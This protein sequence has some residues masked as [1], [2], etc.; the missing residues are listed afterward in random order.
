RIASF[1]PARRAKVGAAALVTALDRRTGFRAE[2]AVHAA[3]ASGDDPVDRAAR[4]FLERSPELADLVREA[5]PPPV[6]EGPTVVALRVQV[7]ELQRTVANL[8]KERDR[9]AARP[10]TDEALER[11]RQRLREQGVRAKADRDRIA[12]L[13]RQ[14]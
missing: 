13:E 12:D 2:V 8:T 9:L 4:A 1:A 6:Q 5:A 7:K 11:L 10:Q 3:A 14:L